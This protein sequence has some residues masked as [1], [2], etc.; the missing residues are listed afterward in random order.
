MNIKAQ[1]AAHPLPPP[2]PRALLTMEKL[3]DSAERLFAQQGVLTASVRDITVMAGQ[4]NASAM[5][6]HFGGREGLVAAV[7]ERHGA[8]VAQDRAEL[9]AELGNDT[10]VASLMRVV[11][12]P[13]ANRLL[14]EPGCRYLLILEQCL[15]IPGLVTPATLNDE[16]T[17]GLRAALQKALSWIPAHVLAR[18]FEFVIAALLGAL[19]VRARARLE[20]MKLSDS[21]AVY[22]DDLV[23]ML[24]AAMAA[25]LPLLMG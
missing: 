1:D 13:L 16:S 10:H 19:A 11:A 14:D 8:R 4:R 21:D 24:A 12:E 3:L 23:E 25:P 5:H 18:R 20:A 22:I 17:Q 15:T 9:M 2:G 6:Y 7:L